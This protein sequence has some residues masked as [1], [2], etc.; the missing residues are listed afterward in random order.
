MNCP[1]CRSKPLEPFSIGGDSL[2]K[3]PECHGLWFNGEELREIE[4][5]P[6]SEL[7]RDFQDKL[8][9]LSPNVEKSATGDRLCP[10]CKKPMDRYQ[11]DVSSGVWVNGCS[12]G[13]GVWL[14]KG[15]L[16]KIH[17]HLQNAMEAL[18]PEKMKAIA[19]QLK[20]IEENEKRSEEEAVMS[21]F[22]NPKNTG[23]LP[24]WHAMDGVCRFMY[25]TF[26][27]L[28]V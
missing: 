5:L 19:T 21:V 26:F 18:P 22:A 20:L 1:A 2:Y 23:A 25:H 16:F 28:G 14:E 4:E 10:E 9:D 11:Y 13:C 3:C 24:L 15:E 12:A 17:H 6:M 7:M 8:D 27:K